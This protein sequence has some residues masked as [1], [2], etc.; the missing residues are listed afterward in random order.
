[1]AAHTAAT[2]RYGELHTDTKTGR[3]FQP[4]RHGLVCRT[5]IGPQLDL[6][7]V[8]LL[9][10]SA[11]GGV[12]Q[13]VVQ[14]QADGTWIAY[15]PNHRQVGEATQTYLDAEAQLLPLRTG[16]RAGCDITWPRDLVWQLRYPTAA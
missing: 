16:Y 1:M 10:R 4:T 9:R 3:E 14:R 15:D 11:K 8:V 5:W 13:G 12:L 6:T 2:A 7:E